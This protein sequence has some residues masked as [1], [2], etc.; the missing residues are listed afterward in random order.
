MLTVIANTI[1]M[2]LAGY[3]E[4]NETI[5]LLNFTFTGIF[6]WEL[7]IKVAAL[8]PMGYIRDPMND[9]DCII[10]IFSIIDLATQSLVNLQAFR[11]LR[12]LRTLRVLRVTKLLRS[13]AFM[14]VIIKVLSSCLI[15]FLNILVL[16]IIFIFIFTL[17][18]SQMFGGNF[19]EEFQYR[20]NW[21]S[22]NNSF[23]NTFQIMTLE[24]WPTLMY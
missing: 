6:I 8:G 5:I 2:G 18:G 11:S 3:V 19:T 12:I 4:E 10:V 17:L 20:Q 7:V 24:N 1:V 16:M 14:K 23:M 15:N 13:L 22:I 9:F 21:D